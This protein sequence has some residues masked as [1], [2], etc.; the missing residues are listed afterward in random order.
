[1][2]KRLFWVGMA[3][4]IWVLASPWVLGF[5][6]V[7]VARWSNIFAGAA[8]ALIILWVYFGRAH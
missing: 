5:E 3:V 1:M 6:G 7:D 4:S 2:D 8:L